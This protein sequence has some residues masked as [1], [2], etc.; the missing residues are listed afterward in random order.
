ML[1]TVS[2][3]LPPCI[4]HTRKQGHNSLGPA[5]DFN[6]SAGQ[7]A[8]SSPTQL[9]LLAAMTTTNMSHLERRV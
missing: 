6:E 5:C 9:L 8:A 4:F 1:V 3:C 2:D 7:A